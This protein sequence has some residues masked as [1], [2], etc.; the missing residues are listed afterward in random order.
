MGALAPSGVD[1][2]GRRTSACEQTYTS[3]EDVHTRVIA[4][5]N[6]SLDY[7]KML[8]SSILANSKKGGAICYPVRHPSCEPKDK[9]PVDNQVR[10][11]KSTNEHNPAL[12]GGQPKLQSVPSILERRRVPIRKK[13]S[14]SLAKPGTNQTYP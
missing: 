7:G 14:V 3:I 13:K 4:A 10:I 12:A 1:G 9:S 5:R 11:E 2:Y 8:T 6:V